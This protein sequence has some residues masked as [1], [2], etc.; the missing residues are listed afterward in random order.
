V[1]LV[2]IAVLLALIP[3]VPAAAQDAPLPPDAVAQVGDELISRSDYDAW[4]API[5]RADKLDPPRF[6]RCVAMLEKRTADRND[7]PSRR[8]LRRR[9]ERRAANL[10]EDV[11]EFLVEAAWVRQ[12]AA[13]LGIAVSLGQVARE[14]ERQKRVAFESEREYRSYLRESGLSEQQILYRVVLN[15]LHA[16]LTRRAT[17]GTPPVTAEDVD[18]Y[19]ERHR[20]RYRGMSRKRA[21]H[22]VSRELTARRQHRALERFTTRFRAR[23]MA[24]TVCAEGYVVSN[25]GSASPNGVPSESRHT[26]Q[27]SPGWIALPPSASTRWSASAMSLT[28]K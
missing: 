28:S 1:R 6:E 10:R 20:R 15:L 8:D 13:R 27:A 24:I 16:R 11:M 9:C 7:Q 26:D 12:E 18:R 14:F 21:L 5:A 4:F 17:A 19:Y 3:A 23:Y 22:W 2:S 25:C